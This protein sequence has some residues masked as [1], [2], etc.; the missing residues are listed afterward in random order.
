[1]SEA[2]P[3]GQ[4]RGQSNPFP[5]W[6]VASLRETFADRV[7]VTTPAVRAARTILDGYALPVHDGSAGVLTAIVGEHGSGRTHILADVLDHA[8]RDP[9]A[10]GST[11]YLR[12]PFD[13]FQ[14]LYRELIYTLS[15]AGVRDRVL[16]PYTDI[17]ADHFEATTFTQELGGQ[18]RTREH[19]ILNIVA[20]LKL[21]H[22]TFLETLR[23]RL[24]EILCND[25]FSIVLPLLLRAGFD[26]VASEWLAGRP[27]AELLRERQVVRAIDD[28]AA[29]VAA[30]CALC[31]LYSAGGRQFILVIDDLAWGRQNSGTADHI[32]QLMQAV[33]ESRAFLIFSILPGE[34]QPFGPD[35]LHQI[36]NIIRPSPFT[37]G[38]AQAYVSAA[39]RDRLDREDT[40]PFTSELIAYM[41]DLAEG[42][43]RRLIQFLYDAYQEYAAS[44]VLDEEMVRRI[45]RDRF[46]LVTRQSADTEI[47]GIL[48]SRAWDYRRRHT[49]DDRL[50]APVDYWIPLNADGAGC[51]LLI[52][53]SVLTLDEAAALAR[54][55]AA[56]R[57]MAPGVETAVVVVGHLVRAAADELSTAFSTEPIVYSPHG[58]ADSLNTMLNRLS[59][60]I[61]HSSD[62]SP[63]A[64]P[65]TL[66][67]VMGDKYEIPGQAG[68]V[69]RG[70]HAH[71]MTF[72]QA[73]RQQAEK[74]DL[75]ELARELEALRQELRGRASTREHDAAV[76]EIGAAAEAAERG[77][78][79]EALNRLQRAGQWALGAATATGAG[80]AAAAIRTALGM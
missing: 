68:A 66:E 78:G 51:A 15:T 37:A 48:S 23:Q 61:S 27:P 76:A 43:P 19:D 21:P 64:Q 11:F 53:E 1:M 47:R 5:V 12:G 22:T 65:T 16:E 58:L 62:Q 29:A 26:G 63:L 32:R 18:L 70:A 39:F 67:V 24:R 77:N 80:V 45:V 14:A 69:G 46:D 54:R 44:D 33:I 20:D 2:T 25:D 8:M 55:S 9:S 28:E 38:D 35:L 59:E 60:R 3:P 36:T 72:Q 74:I 57:T 75:P 7:S 31:R 49:F 56:I 40:G 34:L 30:I 41:A 4:G 79:P 6:T 10:I 13:G 73:W 50:R 71:D 17:V 42:R 52:S